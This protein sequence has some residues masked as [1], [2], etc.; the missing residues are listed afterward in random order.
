MIESV[1][2][3]TIVVV[4]FVVYLKFKNS[5]DDKMPFSSRMR[6]EL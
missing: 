4:T 1:A 3:L 6:D 5:P 2:V